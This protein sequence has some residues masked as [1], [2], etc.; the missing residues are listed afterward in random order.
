MAH[1]NEREPRTA[2]EGR[3]RRRRL[4]DTLDRSSQFKMAVPQ[5]VKAKHPDRD[6]R[7]FNDVGRRIHE[8][9]ILDDWDKVPDVEPLVVG[10]QADGSPLKAILCMKP[11]EF[12]REDEARKDA[13]LKEQERG[14]VRGGTDEADL[15][16]RAYAPRGNA[17]GKVK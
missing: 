6:F 9:T 15:S 3:T 4:D 14:L 12:V 1:P 17:L 2:I 16:E 8:K 11:I 10:A 13:D 5:E 7:W